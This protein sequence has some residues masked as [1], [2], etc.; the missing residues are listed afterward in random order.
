MSK[1][2][3]S[4]CGFAFSRQLLLAAVGSS[5]DG[6]AKRAVK[7]LYIYI[8]YMLHECSVCFPA[9]IGIFRL[10][11]HSEGGNG[12]LQSLGAWIVLGLVWEP[13]SSRTPH[14]SRTAWHSCGAK[15]TIQEERD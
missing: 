12:L 2:L 10:S 4:R 9:G 5:F 6:E 13:H 14:C 15:L 7:V 11:S 8:Y 1:L 3:F